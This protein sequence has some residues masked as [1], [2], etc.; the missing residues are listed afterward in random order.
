MLSSRDE[1]QEPQQG[2]LPGLHLHAGAAY[3]TPFGKDAFRRTMSLP[4]QAA[5]IKVIETHV[6]LAIGIAGDVTNLERIVLGRYE[7]TELLPIRLGQ[8]IKTTPPS[9]PGRPGNAPREASVRRQPSLRPRPLR[10][11]P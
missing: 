8:Q 2:H 11:A 4:Y 3:A 9:A 10:H 6:A 7:R 5:L 1:D